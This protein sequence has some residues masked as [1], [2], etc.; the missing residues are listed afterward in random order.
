MAAECPAAATSDGGV[1][2]AITQVIMTMVIMGM[3]IIRII[4]EIMDINQK[5][6]KIN[7]DIEVRDPTRH[8]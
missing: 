2:R 1:N 5:M 8:P 3:I 6:I 7:P 4:M